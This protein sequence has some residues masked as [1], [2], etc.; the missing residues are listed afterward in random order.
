MGGG[1]LQVIEGAPVLGEVFDVVDPPHPI[2]EIESN[3]RRQE[4]TNGL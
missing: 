4:T 2:I 1:M 3:P